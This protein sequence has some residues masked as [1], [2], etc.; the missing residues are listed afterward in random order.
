MNGTDTDFASL[1]QGKNCL[2]KGD[3]GIETKELQCL[4]VKSIDESKRQIHAIAST[5]S[6]DRHGEI[7]KLSALKKAI[8]GYMK[9][10]VILACHAH[11]LDDGR[12]PTVAKCIKSWVDKSGLNIIIEF[13]KTSLGDEYWHL[14]SEKFQ[15]AFSIGFRVLTVE[16]ETIKSDRVPVITELDLFEISCVPVPANQDALSKAEQRKHDFVAAKRQQRKTGLTDARIKEIFTPEQMKHAYDIV[17]ADKGK[18]YL[19]QVK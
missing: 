9:N 14:Y 18:S 4:I 3:S 6:I 7:V 12:S 11:R 8:P 10:P 1:V 16:Y 13:A 15:R 17:D 19:E 2:T 5:E